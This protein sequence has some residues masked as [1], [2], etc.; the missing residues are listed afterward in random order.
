MK[1]SRGALLYW[2][3][4]L[5]LYREVLFL[6]IFGFTGKVAPSKDNNRQVYVAIKSR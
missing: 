6:V 3:V 2:E 5:A 4:S 1:L